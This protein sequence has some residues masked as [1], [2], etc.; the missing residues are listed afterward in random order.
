M[1]E[2]NE[3]VEAMKTEAA[4]EQKNEVQKPSNQRTSPKTAAATK[5]DKSKAASTRTNK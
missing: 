1:D 4:Q 3:A 5:A 2:A